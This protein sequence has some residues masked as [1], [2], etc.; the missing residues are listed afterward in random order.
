MKPTCHSPKFCSTLCKHFFLSECTKSNT[1]KYWLQSFP[2]YF[3][4][5]YSMKNT[6]K[7]TDLLHFHDTGKELTPKERHKKCCTW[8]HH[9]KKHPLKKLHYIYRQ[10]CVHTLTLC[11]K[12]SHTHFFFYRKYQGGIVLLVKHYGNQLRG[13]GNF[14][15]DINIKCLLNVLL[16]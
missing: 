13:S 1:N 15:I 12:A 8:N 11:Y 16:T 4:K 14:T 7:T 3:Y 6:H 2:L 10:W 9:L 5:G